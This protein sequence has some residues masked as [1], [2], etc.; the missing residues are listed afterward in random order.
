MTRQPSYLVLLLAIGAAAAGRL[1]AQRVAPTAADSAAV[2]SLTVDSVVALELR[3]RAAAARLRSG[4]PWASSDSLAAA[5][6]A[7]READDARAGS[8]HV[9]A[10]PAASWAAAAVARL[11]R[12]VEGG[13]PRDTISVFGPTFQGDSAWVTDHRSA[14]G[15]RASGGRWFAGELRRYLLVRVAG[16][17]QVVRRESGYVDG[18]LAR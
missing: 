1:A 5:Y 11:R 16:G 12:V 13:P 17:W 9:G 10:V 6:D 2:F 4:P 18:I 7:L 14:T 15:V 8:V 3:A